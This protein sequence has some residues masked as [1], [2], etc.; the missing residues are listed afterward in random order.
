MA[1]GDSS[2]TSTA[3]ASSTDETLQSVTQALISTTRSASRLA[4]EDLPFHRSLDRRT[5]TSLDQQNERLL[6]LARRLLRCAVGEVAAGVD[7]VGGNLFFLFE[8]VEFL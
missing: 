7:A 2:T 6:A 8:E 5:A 3:T 1:A 4:S